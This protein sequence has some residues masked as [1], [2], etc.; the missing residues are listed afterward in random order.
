MFSKNPEFITRCGP[1][2]LPSAYDI[3]NDLEP[4]GV[5][6]TAQNSCPAAA[7]QRWRPSAGQASERPFLVQWPRPRLCSVLYARDPFEIKGAGGGEWALFSF[8]EGRTEAV[9]MGLD[10]GL[11][12]EEGTGSRASWARPSGGSSGWLW[13]QTYKSTALSLEAH[14]VP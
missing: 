9:F 14:A 7:R 2:A 1:P 3:L 12:V 11:W 10:S 13:V 8:A 4:R 6:R 5:F